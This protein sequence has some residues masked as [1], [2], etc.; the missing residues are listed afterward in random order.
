MSKRVLLVYPH[1]IKGW[2]A[3]LRVEIPMGLLCI[4]TAVV[5]EGYDVKIID[6]RVDPRWRSIL[7]EELR[8]DP[9]CVGVSSM[10]GPQLRYALEISKIVKDYGNVPV[11]WGGI[12]PTIL[13]DQ[14]LRN[15]F[16]DFIVQGEGEETFL[17]LVQAL[18]GKKSLGTVKGI[19]YKDHGQIKDTGIRPFVDLNQQPPLAYY[20]VDLKEY[21]RVI[22]GVGHLNFL[23]SRGC[24]YP[25]TFCFTGPFHSKSWRSMDSDLVVQRIKDFVQKYHVKGL[26]FIDNNFFTDIE[27]GRTILKG[28]IREDLGIVISK[29]SIR[30]DTLLRMKDDDFA[31]LE[32]AG[33]RRLTI[34]VESGS[35]R[36]R[37]LLK[38]PID[39]PGIR[40]LNR[41]LKNS[42]LVPS[43]LFMMGLPT[44]TKEELAESVSLSL[45][46]LDENPKAKTF[47]NIYTP[48]P[49]TELFDIAVKHGL[50]VP[51]RLEDWGSFNY[52]NLT[53]GAP[54][55][56]EEMRHIVEMLD[57]STFFIGRGP[58]FQAYERTSL[59]V[60]L[61][62]NLYAPLAN[63]RVK[64]FWGRFP[65]EI[66][67]AKLFGLYAKQE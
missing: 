34:A 17:E 57:F 20:L 6:Q 24:A 58:F 59:W 56:P 4:A 30:P 41:R 67:L 49:G 14:T 23:T 39:V 29:I 15:E 60:S 64:H 12:H 2:Q 43:L 45:R 37:A 51:E 50:H 1:I 46:L 62:C 21:L 35:E 33:C 9:I 26:T 31:L 53:Q 16:I 13:P 54:W 10:T 52:R 44:E 48:F 25:C 27:R 18:E 22:S 19:C 40:E 55:L 66:K 47:F 8:K 36:I 5:Q 28:L 3:Q 42:L 11:V 61:L 7:E 63:M 32:Q 38:K 65:V